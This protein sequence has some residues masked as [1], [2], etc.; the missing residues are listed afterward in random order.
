[1]AERRR[2][3]RADRARGPARLRARETR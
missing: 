3:D 1:V 2:R